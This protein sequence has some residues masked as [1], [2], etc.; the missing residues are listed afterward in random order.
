[1]MPVTLGLFVGNAI[2]SVCIILG[3]ETKLLLGFV[4][5]YKAR[6]VFRQVTRV[7]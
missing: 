2:R 5:R 4:C 6:W 7:G 1:M 3:L